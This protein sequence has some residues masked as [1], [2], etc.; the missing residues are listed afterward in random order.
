MS[1]PEYEE[2]IDNRRDVFRADALTTRFRGYP[3]KVQTDCP[4]V[5][6]VPKTKMPIE[7]SYDPKALYGMGVNNGVLE[8]QF[9]SMPDMP[10]C[11]VPLAAEDKLHYGQAAQRD[12]AA[13]PCLNGQCPTSLSSETLDRDCNYGFARTF[14]SIFGPSSGNRYAMN[15][16]G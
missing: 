2:R 3:C 11:G 10:F 7:T 6:A 15:R 4:H 5:S 16:W 12:C 8:Y 1:L 9:T 14:S 13:C